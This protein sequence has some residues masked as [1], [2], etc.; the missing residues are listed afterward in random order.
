MTLLRDDEIFVCSEDLKLLF[1]RYR[2]KLVRIFLFVGIVIFILLI[3]K[4][5]KY[6]AMATFVQSSSKSEQLNHELKNLLKEVGVQQGIET[7]TRSTMLSHHV[8]RMVVQELGF[9]VTVYPHYFITALFTRIG[10]NLLR[11]LGGRPG[12]RDVFEFRQVVYEEE[13]PAI[14][15]LRFLTPDTFEVLNEKKEVLSRGKLKERISFEKIHMIVEKGP[16]NVST[17]RMYKLKIR[18][19]PE[20]VEGLQKKFRINKSKIDKNILHLTFAHPNRRIAADFLNRV[21]NAY[22]NYLMEENEHIA[23][24]QLAYLEKRQEELTLKMDRTLE[25]HTAYLKKNLGDIGFIGLNQEI[26]MLA[27]PREEYIS[28]LFDVDLE[29][30]RMQRAKQ[31]RLLLGRRDN[32]FHLAALANP[33]KSKSKVPV[34]EGIDLE[35]ARKL[36]LTYNHHL[37]EI[38]ARI[39]ELFFVS[40]K[41]QSADFEL[42]SLCSVLTDPVS[43]EML[44]KASH[45]ALQLQ[46]ENNRSL[47]EQIRLKEAL[48]TQKQFILQHIAHMI[49]L[50]KLR[51]QLIEEKLASLQDISIELIKNEKKLIKDKLFEIKQRMS[52]LPEKWRLENKLK[53]KSELCKSMMEGMSR[54]VEFKNVNH[55][56]FQ[57]ESKP[58]DPARPPLKPMYPALL[59]LSVC[60]AFLGTGASFAFLVGRDV[61]KGLPVSLQSLKIH[62]F[63]AA[64]KWSSDC[65]CPFSEIRDDDLETL[66]RIASFISSQKRPDRGLCAALVGGNNP[67]YSKNLAC[68]LSMKGYKTILIQCAFDQAVHPQDIPGLW[69]YLQGEVE[70]CPIRLEKSFNF[71][72]SGGTSRHAAELFSNRKFALLL[73]EYKQ[74]YDL[75]L[76]YSTARPLYADGHVFAQKADVLVVTASEETL[77]QLGDWSKQKEEGRVLFTIYKKEL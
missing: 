7:G 27:S 41:I 25:E 31:N 2:R 30:K 51:T 66:R 55:H 70:T 54:L 39:G 9:Q 6:K 10:N 57:V 68:L 42:S 12:D 46:D 61:L 67:D 76:I 15:F 21:M 13:T 53:L 43:Q 75:V 14:L 62:Q 19:W 5:P 49:E 40:E 26:E 22:Q 37:D 58:L 77:E 48:S 60:G 1:G 50:A 63:P 24:A 32:Q 59:L 38:Q 64:G 16:C 11:E 23:Q 52:D 36:Y 71:V 65:D 8:M 47:K 17:K 44:H 33:E 28:R 45:L 34:L 35:T 29:L 69:H 3:F 56:L 18:P 72:P 73:E 20:V 4:A 74:N